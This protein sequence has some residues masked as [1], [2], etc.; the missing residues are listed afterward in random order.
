MTEHALLFLSLT[1]ADRECQGRTRVIED[2]LRLIRRAYDEA[3]AGL[4]TVVEIKVVA[5]KP[6]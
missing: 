5:R 2:A 6:E 3:S 4:E 1:P